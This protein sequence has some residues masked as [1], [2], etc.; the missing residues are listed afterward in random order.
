MARRAKKV[1]VEGIEFDSLKDACD[2]YGIIRQTY[3]LRRKK[4]MS[5]EEAFTRPKY[6][7]FDTEESVRR[8]Y[9]KVVERARLLG[10]VL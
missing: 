3:N 10:I 7:K 1:E 4:G 6:L 2:V 9:R 5:V 8:D